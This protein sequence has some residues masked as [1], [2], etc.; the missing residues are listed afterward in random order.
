MPRCPKTLTRSSIGRGRT[1]NSEEQRTQAKFKKGKGKPANYRLY[2]TAAADLTA[3]RL[4]LG[5]KPLAVEI[6]HIKFL[7]G[8]DPTPRKIALRNA[9]AD[10]SQQGYPVASAI[11][12][13]TPDRSNGW[14]IAPE[15]GKPHV[16]AFEFAQPIRADGGVVLTF[17]LN[18]QFNSQ[19]HNLGRF[20]L[21]VTPD[22]APHGFGTPEGIVKILAAAPDQRSAEDAKMLADYARAHDPV[23][24]AI[25]AELAAAEKPL[26]V[27]PM[28][29][30]LSAN[31]AKAGEPF[32][33]PTE[34]VRL[35]N[36]FALS[37]SQLKAKRLTVSQDI[38]W[39]L[40]N[41]PSFLFNR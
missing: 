34:L 25:D 30:E 16:A 41:S 40:I 35:R 15:M 29:A 2:F 3:L 33:V 23:R 20:R 4:D 18:Q 39:A 11:D 9:Q 17:K 7:R 32:P 38:A 19:Q 36:D 26:P 31:L 8:A 21:S 6:D 24:H 14:A 27:D 1:G 5:S 37:E 28:I 10:F 12:G 22:A 13:Q